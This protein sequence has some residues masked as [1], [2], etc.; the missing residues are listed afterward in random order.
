MYNFVKAT[1]IAVLFTISPPAL[2]LDLDTMTNHEKD[3]FGQQ[4]REYLLQ[5]P[6]VIMQVFSIL[7][8]RQQAA[9]L[10]QDT[11]LV[12]AYLP[13]IQNDGFSWVGGNP[14][15]D[16]TLVEFLDYKCGYCRKAHNEVA[17]LVKTDGNIKLVVKEY[18]ILGED[19]YDLSRAAVATLQSLGNDA[20]KKM[21]NQFIKHDGPVTDDVITYLANKVDLDGQIIV[22]KMDDASVAE[23]ISKTRQLGE[24]LNINGTPTF[25]I[26][27]E[28]IRGYVP[29][30]T[31][32]AI[33][34][35]LRTQTQ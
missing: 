32:K 2:A 18:P 26:N 3:L 19:S 4:V 23:Q 13:E 27:G 25:I 12:S 15:G 31:M 10:Q 1:V 9:E 8:Q 6:D 28:I 11:T 5:N 17:N 29:A 16:I 14:A 30:D 34:A 33:I 20:Y 35:E 7:E 22:A 21:Y 24:N